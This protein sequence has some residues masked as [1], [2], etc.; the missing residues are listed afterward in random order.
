MS[1][2]VNNHT[3]FSEQVHNLLERGPDPLKWCIVMLLLFGIVIVWH[4]VVAGILAGIAAGA[5]FGNYRGRSV[6]L[7][8][9]RL[10]M[11]LDHERRMAELESAYSNNTQG[12]GGR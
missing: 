8:A 1:T 3:G 12:K 9:W 11:S 10:Q 6:V 5:Y 7:K 2:T 4:S